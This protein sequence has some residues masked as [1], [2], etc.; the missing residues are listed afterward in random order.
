VDHKSHQH[1]HT[2]THTYNMHTGTVT[3]LPGVWQA[4]AV[5]DDDEKTKVEIDVTLGNKCA[6]DWTFTKR[7]ATCVVRY[8]EN[9][10]CIHVYVCHIVYMYI[11]IYIY[12]YIELQGT[13]KRYVCIHV[14]VV[15]VYMCVCGVCIH[16][17]GVCIHVCV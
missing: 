15:G 8:R 9:Y 16:V 12:I 17:C 13:E 1:I 7:G 4:T 5:M 6:S 14:C 11:Y 3:S 2:Y 10:V